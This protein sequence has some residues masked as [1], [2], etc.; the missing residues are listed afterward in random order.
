MQDIAELLL[1]TLKHHSEMQDLTLVGWSTIRL[2]WIETK[3]RAQTGVHWNDHTQAINVEFQANDCDNVGSH[4][5]EYHLFAVMATSS[6]NPN[7]GPWPLVDCTAWDATLLDCWAEV[8]RIHPSSSTICKE[9][10][11]RMLQPRKSWVP[12]VDQQER[13]IGCLLQMNGPWNGGFLVVFI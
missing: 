5:N 8:T 10:L 7:I 4:Y 12:K 11:Q 13:S 3:A 1:W 9:F 2:R 6:F